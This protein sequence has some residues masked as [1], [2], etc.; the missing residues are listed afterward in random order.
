MKVNSSY[1]W[2]ILI[3]N[4]VIC[5]MAYAG[6][7][8]W[9]MASE[10]L[11]VTFEISAVQASIGSGILMAGYAVGSY[12]EATLTNKIGYRG[13]GLLGLVL[14]VIGTIGI[15]LAGN[16]N[17]ILFLRFLQGWASCGW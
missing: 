5:A 4:F 13:A 2:V 17:L 8:M 1:R 6:L 11:A 7:T 3:I 15:P 10:D 16:Y 14:M 12:V 9:S